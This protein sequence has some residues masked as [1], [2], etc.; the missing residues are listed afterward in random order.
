[1]NVT[2][3][4]RPWTVWFEAQPENDIIVCHRN[5]SH[6][7]TEGVETQLNYTSY[8]R[9]GIRPHPAYLTPEALESWNSAVAV[10]GW[11]S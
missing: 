3:S 7:I 4:P 1:M 11:D 5:R 6:P 8:Q 2:Y 10:M 9:R